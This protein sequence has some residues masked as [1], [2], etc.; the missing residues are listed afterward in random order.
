LVVGTGSAGGGYR[1]KFGVVGVTDGVFTDQIQGDRDRQE[2]AVAHRFFDDGES[3]LVVL[4]DGMGGH[5]GGA[6]ASQTTVDS[7]TNAFL[8]DFPALKVSYRLFGAMA[9]AN[10][11]LENLVRKN[12]SL[13]G[14]GSTLVAATFSSLGISWV[15]VGDSLLLR[16]R[17][18]TLH[19]LNQDHSMAPILDEAV[20]KGNLTRELAATHKDRN[21][22]RSAVTG[23]EIDLV[24]IPDRPESLLAGDVILLASDGLRTLSDVEITRVVNTKKSAGARAIVGGLLEA[25]REKKKRR[26]DNTT[27]AAIV[28]DRPSLRET[29]AGRPRSPSWGFGVAAFVC[30]ILIAIVL[31]LGLSLFKPVS[32]FLQVI[33]KRVQSDWGVLIENSKRESVEES[34]D[35]SSLPAREDAPVNVTSTTPYSE[36]WNSEEVKPSVGS[37]PAK[38]GDSRDHRPQDELEVEGA[39]AGVTLPT[40]V[41][42]PNVKDDVGSVTTQKNESSASS[43]YPNMSP[44]EK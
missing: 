19:R 32:D 25:V 42:G 44:R 30:S 41:E 8:T 36:A 35:I 5:Q 37:G 15:S 33:S 7:F 31:G 38:P 6:V 29:L 27:V 18:R 23:T 39:S 10:E 13:E 21:A 11:E 1:M 16:V 4:A 43:K 20:K 2:D 28:I 34:V 9:R 17:G 40:V 3:M 22:L 24:D 12:G 26:Q 14:M